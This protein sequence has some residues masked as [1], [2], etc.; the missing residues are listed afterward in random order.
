MT[1][2]M[3]GILVLSGIVIGGGVMAL[4]ID[5]KTYK[6]KDGRTPVSERVMEGLAEDLDLTD[7]Q[8]EALSQILKDNN[9]EFI[10]IRRNTSRQI[11]QVLSRMGDEIKT[12]LTPEQ[13]Q[14]WEAKFKKHRR[15]AMP[16]YPHGYDR[17]DPRNRWR[18][19]GRNG[20][21]DG[22]HR[23]RDN[24]RDGRPRPPFNDDEASENEPPPID[25]E[26]GNLRPPNGE[27][28]DPPPHPPNRDFDG[29]RPPPPPPQ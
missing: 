29:E 9:E 14:K 12:V 13:A 15:R 8:Q 5:N 2:L 10:W 18:D 26:T 23:P 25:D 6:S 11:D 24:N 20:G 4:V 27:E 19:H 28:F 1:L 22:Q 21:R 3:G 16:G 7:E 17:N